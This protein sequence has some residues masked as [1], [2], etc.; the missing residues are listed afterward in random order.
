MRRIAAVTTIFLPATFLATFFSMMFFHT[1]EGIVLKVSSTIWVYFVCTAVL[2]LVIVLHFRFASHWQ[3]LRHVFG[4]FE[5][6]VQEAAA[7]DEE[8]IKEI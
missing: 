8:K 3:K 2:S 5:R 6:L 7:G 4:R 1:D